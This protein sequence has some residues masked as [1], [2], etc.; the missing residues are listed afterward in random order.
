MNKYL[1]LYQELDFW[2]KSAGIS[3][4]FQFFVT[5]KTSLYATLGILTKTLINM[6]VFGYVT[7][8]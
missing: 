8:C 2:Y 7:L 5:R 6:H 3:G 4:I 1:L